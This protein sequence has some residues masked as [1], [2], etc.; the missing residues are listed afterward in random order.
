M[1]KQYNL[2]WGYSLCYQGSRRLHG[3]GGI[4]LAETFPELPLIYTPLG[5]YSG[6]QHL[7]R[8]PGIQGPSIC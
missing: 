5:A 8:L 6:P 1:C 7:T 2:Y 3:G 4:G